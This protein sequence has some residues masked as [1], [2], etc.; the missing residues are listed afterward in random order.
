MLPASWW[1]IDLRDG[2][3]R[4]RLIACL[5]AQEVGPQDE[6]ATVRAQLRSRL[7]GASHDAAAAGGRL[8][9]VSLMRAA[10]IPL[11]A[12]VTVYRVPGAGVPGDE[13]EHLHGALEEAPVP[14]QELEL[15]MGIEGPVLRRV[16]VRTATDDVD[17]PAIP[18]LLVDYW[19]DPQDGHGL[20]LMSFSSPLVTAR[21]G[22]LDLFDLIV[23]SVGPDEGES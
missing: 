2:D 4:R 14:G 1:I 12:T 9:A 5:V 15:A 19:L 23:A 11:T 3:V 21:E 22:L 13:L 20:V 10:G 16:Y 18:M 17:A 8:V 7:D 6:L